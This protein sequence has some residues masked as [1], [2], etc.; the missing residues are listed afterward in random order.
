MPLPPGPSSMPAVLTRCRPRTLRDPHPPANF[1]RATAPPHTAPGPA[2][3][4][5][6]PRTPR[7]G[8]AGTCFPGAPRASPGAARRAAGTC[9]P[10]RGAEPSSVS[11]LLCRAKPGA[12]GA[13]PGAAQGG[14]KRD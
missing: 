9:S 3:E 6:G 8:G 4:P 14:G 11:S 10:L 2:P 13:G 12:C 1:P 7:G 5:G